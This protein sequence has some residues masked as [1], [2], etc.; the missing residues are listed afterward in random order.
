MAEIGDYTEFLAPVVAAAAQFM[1][2]TDADGNLKTTDP[3]IQLAALM[4]LSQ[5][6]GY[7]KRP[8]INDER[9]EVYEHFNPKGQELRV[10]PVDS[11]SKVELRYNASEWEVV[12]PDDYTLDGNVLTILDTAISDIAVWL[13][14]E[15]DAGLK[16]VRVTYVAGLD[17][18]E[19]NGLLLSGLTVQAVANY[20]RRD[21]LGFSSVTS[22]KG[23][24]KVPSD[25][26]DVVQ[27]AETIV[28]PLVYYGEAY[29]E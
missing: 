9:R 21:L 10:I 22:D 19:E 5:I 20:H 26:G 16:D 1:E 3:V 4:A 2:V 28:A 27:A 23:T 11:I 7:C 29:E 24:A 18:I 12:S 25:A 6:S 14:G 17:D 13:S 15:D 8:F